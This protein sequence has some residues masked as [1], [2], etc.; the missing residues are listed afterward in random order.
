MGHQSIPD[1]GNTWPTAAA[2]NT[3]LAEC[4]AVRQAMYNAFDG[5][6]QDRRAGLVSPSSIMIVPDSVSTDRDRGFPV[7]AW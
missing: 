1:D 6:P 2:I 7:K 4:H 5:V 3:A